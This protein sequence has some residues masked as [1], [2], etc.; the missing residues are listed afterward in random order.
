MSNRANRARAPIPVGR[1]PKAVTYDAGTG[2][3]FVTNYGSSNVSVISGATH[4]RVA[5]LDV[6]AGPGGVAS[7]A[8][9][10]AIYVSNGYQGTISV[11]GGP[12][13]ES[14]PGVQGLPAWIVY[15]VVLIVAAVVVTGLLFSRSRMRTKH[16]PTEP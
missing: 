13:S 16:P 1:H 5:T 2:N 9:T 11:I 12:Q 15:L 10:G 8:A 4:A 3:V 14:G 6:G 7:D